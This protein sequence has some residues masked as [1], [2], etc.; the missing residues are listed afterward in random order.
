MFDRHVLIGKP[1]CSLRSPVLDRHDV[2]L[3]E[4]G[5]EGDAKQPTYPEEAI[6]FNSLQRRFVTRTSNLDRRAS[7]ELETSFRRL[8]H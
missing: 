8:A 7:L 1:S 3:Q 5:P 2:R 4:R 6:R